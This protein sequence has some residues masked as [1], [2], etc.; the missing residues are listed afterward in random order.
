MSAAD[1][2]PAMSA[3]RGIAGRIVA[4]SSVDVYRAYGRMHGSEPGPPEPIPLHEES[5]LREKLFPY[6][7]E[8]GAKFDDYDKIPV[9]QAMLG[10]DDPPGT[11]LRLPAVHGERDNQRRLRAEVERMDA[12]RPAIALP[13][14]A[15]NWR[16]SR[17]YAGNIADAIVL[18]LTDDRA[19]GRIYNVAEPETLTQ[20][21][22]TQAIADAIGWHGAIMPVPD[23]SLPAHLK[24]PIDFRQ[25]MVVDSSRIRAE[26]GF[27]ER[28]SPAEGIRRSIEWERAQP[29]RRA[30]KREAEYAAEDR[31][32]SSIQHE[33]RHMINPR[34][35]GR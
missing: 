23:A 30:G 9:E 18:A 8:M 1:A 27:R 34:I 25:D 20:A 3:F 17:S 28:I 10:D 5:P 14:A 15:H 21:E 22:W 6:R 13:M 11:I 12:S 32:L 29:Q 24:L 35:A 4:I 16:W 19:A 7:G 33:G 31:A 2:E 26:L